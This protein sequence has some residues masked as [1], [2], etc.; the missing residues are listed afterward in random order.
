MDQ[1]R[2][3][4]LALLTPRIT[5]AIMARS[6]SLLPVAASQ[7][8]TIVKK[9]TP[10]GFI[11]KVRPWLSIRI[12]LSLIGLIVVLIHAGLPTQVQLP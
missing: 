10:I 1:L 5:G 11:K 7:L 6:S 12:A 3:S 4:A 2:I 8:C 9:S